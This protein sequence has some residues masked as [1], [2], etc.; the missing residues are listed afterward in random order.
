MIT[1]GE[2]VALDDKTLQVHGEGVVQIEVRTGVCLGRVG[3]SGGESLPELRGEEV[4]GVKGG[5]DAASAVPKGGLEQPKQCVNV[6]GYG[7][8][9]PEMT[10]GG[11]EGEVAT[12]ETRNAV[13]LRRVEDPGHVIIEELPGAGFLDRERALRHLDDEPGLGHPDVCNVLDIVLSDGDLQELGRCEILGFAGVYTSGSLAL[14][15][16]SVGALVGNDLE[17]VG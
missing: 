3:D 12:E 1:V 17:V 16:E 4:L 5:G 8:R 7:E 13:F 6:D 15:M 9:A 14:G 2:G 10:R 11:D